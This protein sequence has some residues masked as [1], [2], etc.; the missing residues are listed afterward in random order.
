MLSAISKKKSIKDAFKMI[1]NRFSI[2][3]IAM[4]VIITIQ[5]I[6]IGGGDTTPVAKLC[7]TY[8]AFASPECW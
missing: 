7:A 1:V 5:N 2:F 8:G 4:L 3:F 6:L